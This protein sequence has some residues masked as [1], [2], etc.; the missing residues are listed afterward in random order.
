VNQYAK[1]IV[2]LVGL[3]AIGAVNAG[4]IEGD[5]AQWVNVVIAALTTVGVFAIPNKPA[6]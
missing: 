2:A 6:A 1:T 5:A 3:I 4:L